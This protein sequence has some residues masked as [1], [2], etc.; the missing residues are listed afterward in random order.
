MKTVVILNGP[1]DTG[2][3]YMADY[4]VTHHGFTKHE[5]KAPLRKILHEI[6]TLHMGELGPA[7]C[8]QLELNRSLKESERETMFGNRTWREMMIW[9]SENVIKPKFGQNAFGL[10]A[11][12]AVMNETNEFIVFSD[13]GFPEERKMLE[14]HNNVVTV[15]IRWEGKTFEGDSR[16]YLPDPD[17]AFHV[18]PDDYES[19]HD[20]LD[21]LA[22]M[23]KANHAIEN[24]EV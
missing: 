23:L 15:H 12:R 18:K 11:L 22:S 5:M 24:M 3:D 16:D 4:L 7:R 13:C 20:W 21:L 8:A 19:T 9:V 17:Y 1:K 6:S 2:K 10:A 14:G